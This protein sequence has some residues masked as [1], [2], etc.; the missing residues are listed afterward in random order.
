MSRIYRVGHSEADS[1]SRH[2][3]TYQSLSIHI[4]MFP[5]KH[6]ES[7]AGHPCTHERD[8]GRKT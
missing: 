6:G 8:F 2:E 3:G 5:Q 7:S 4:A 1:T